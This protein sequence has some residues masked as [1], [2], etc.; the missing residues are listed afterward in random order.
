LGPGQ[1]AVLLTIVAAGG[2]EV[3]AGIELEV[4][5]IEESEGMEEEDDETT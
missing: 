2:E 3:D 4:E 1:V 5:G